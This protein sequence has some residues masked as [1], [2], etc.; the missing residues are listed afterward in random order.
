MVFA[1]SVVRCGG[2]EAGLPVPT[3]GVVVPVVALRARS[4]RWMSI[5]ARVFALLCV[6][7]WSGTA[8]AQQYP[9]QRP[10]W[11]NTWP[12]PDGV[13]GGPA[14]T[15]AFNVISV[16]VPPNAAT[17]TITVTA[18]RVAG[19]GIG[20]NICER[21]FYGAEPGLEC[22][23]NWGGNYSGGNSVSY[24]VSYLNPVGFEDNVFAIG[25]SGNGASDPGFFTYSITSNVPYS[26]ECTTNYFSPVEQTNI[27]GSGGNYSTVFTPSPGCHSWTMSGIPGWISGFPA[28]GSGART[29]NYSVAP[30]G[31]GGRGASITATT[32]TAPGTSYNIS[33]QPNCTYSLNSTSAS[34]GAGG[35]GGSFNEQ[36]SGGACAWT[37]SPP[38]SDRGLLT[39][40]SAPRPWRFARARPSPRA[41]AFRG[42]RGRRFHGSPSR[43]ARR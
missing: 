30:S 19:T 16:R 31:T 26:T 32:G 2:D 9:I 7:A 39:W 33:Q 5:V 27:P 14:T 25:V 23:A 22:V 13:C 4:S 41:R 38:T 36:A 10:Q 12:R 37:L 43:I 29:I 21:L 28:S 34:P 15:R 42:R 6:L 1:A 17:A 40:G 24:T 20:I 11:P 18:T 35:G 3:G 8:A